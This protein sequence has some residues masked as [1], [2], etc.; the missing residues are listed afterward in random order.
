M[1]TSNATKKL[2]NIL[3][4]LVFFVKKK[5]QL[6][7]CF[8]VSERSPVSSNCI[9]VPVIHRLTNYSTLLNKTLGLKLN[10]NVA[11]RQVDVTGWSKKLW[12]RIPHVSQK[13][14]FKVQISIKV[15][16]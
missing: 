7:S 8:Q 9:Q 5:F 4:Y 1:E 14:R 11:K 6:A 13:I 3:D 12:P 15:A 10:R 16:S 2:K